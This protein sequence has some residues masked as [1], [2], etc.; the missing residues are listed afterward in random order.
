MYYAIEELKAISDCPVTHEEGK[1]CR[2]IGCIVFDKS[3]HAQDL[4]KYILQIKEEANDG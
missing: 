3:C 1:H 2:G 4:A